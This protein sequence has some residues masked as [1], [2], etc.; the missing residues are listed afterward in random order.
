VPLIGAA[1]SVKVLFDPFIVPLG[2]SP[3][4]HACCQI[5]SVEDLA[6]NTEPLEGAAELPIS[7]IDVAVFNPVAPDDVLPEAYSN[8]TLLP[9]AGVKVNVTLL[10]ASL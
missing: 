2:V 6:T 8:C 4:I 9:E 3:K 5:A 7:T 10:S 1:V